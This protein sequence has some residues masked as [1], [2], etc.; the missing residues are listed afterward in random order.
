ML[1]KDDIL[2]RKAMYDSVEKKI[3]AFFE[4][5]GFLF[6]RT[7]LLVKSPGMEPNLDPFKVEVKT[8]NP[9]SSLSAGL[10]TS[11]EYSMKK[12]LGAGLEKIYTMTPVFRNGESLGGQHLP[13]FQMLEWYASGD[14][15]DLM[16]ETEDLLNSVLNEGNWPR[17]SYNDAGMDDCGD[18]HVYAKRF[19]VTKYPVDQASLAR[20][21]DEGQYAERFEAFADGF[22]LCNGF[23]ELTDAKVQRKRFDAEA[24]E[25]KRLGKAIFPIDEEL[26][27]AIDA[28]D[29]P[30]YGNAL[31]IDRLVMLAY[32]VSD[33]KDIQIFPYA[34]TK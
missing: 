12:L 18:P 33:I 19:F 10:I 25:R 27:S 7:P 8:Q 20:I 15:E 13:E 24:E 11:P 26:L 3:H 9:V 21:E 34:F 5:R 4:A 6:V 2:H 22:E 23:C 1:S 14:Y 29:G 31:G 32:G 16:Q 17:I 28:I 30:V